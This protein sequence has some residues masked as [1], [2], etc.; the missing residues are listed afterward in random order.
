MDEVVVTSRI[1]LARNLS[2]V[3]FTIKMNDYDAGLVIDR[4][5][6]VISKN[7]QYKFDFY[8]IRK[9][10]LLKRQ[11]L[12]E[13]HLISPALVSS[14]IK[15]AVAIDQNENIS[16]MINEEDHLRIQVLYRGQ[17]IQMAWEDA[18]RIDDF[19][20]EHLPYAYDET[21][22]Y[23]TS[24]PT[25]V[26]TGLRASFMLHLPALTLL[27]YMKEIIETITKLGIAVRGFYGEG[28]EVVGNLY[29]IS[30]QITLG[31]PEEDIIA[32]VISI[33]N[34]IIEQ[35][36]QARLKLL[37]ENRAFIEDKVYRSFGILKYARNISSN[38]ALRL[39]SDVRMGISMG[40]I[41]EVT[42]DK[43]DVLL[44][45]IQPAMIQDYFGREMTPEER[46]IKRAELIRKILD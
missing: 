1:R 33:T 38:E 9:L 34:Q 46:D 28:S 18:N 13:K 3:P 31:Q 35:E 39:I 16:I 22:G 15:S 27:G 26:G 36:R 44:N 11:V 5:R 23:L 24:C 25:N 12:I 30:N 8:E 10:P 45:L 6:D 14:K 40:I 41:K 37:N 42:I 21:W 2:D 43:I 29:Q 19:L 17:N 7:K 32:N 4:V 20:E